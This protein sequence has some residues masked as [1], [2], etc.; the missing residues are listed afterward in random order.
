MLMSSQC[1]EVRGKQAFP[2]ICQSEQN[3]S[4]LMDLGMVRLLSVNPSVITVH[5]QVCR[6]MSHTHY[7]GIQSNLF[8]STLEKNKPTET[9]LFQKCTVHCDWERAKS[10]T[11]DTGRYK[12]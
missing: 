12:N 2:N 10:K 8:T 9:D 3:M 5:S 1:E 6:S 7:W 4:R 11:I